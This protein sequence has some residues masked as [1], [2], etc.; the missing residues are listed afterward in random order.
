M[1]LQAEVKLSPNRLLLDGVD[2]FFAVLP[3]EDARAEMIRTG[4]RF[5]RSHRLSGSLVDIERLHLKLAPIG[6]P[7]RLREPPEGALLAAAEAVRARAFRITLD[8]AMRF[9]TPRRDGRFPFVLCSDKPTTDTAFNLRRALAD[10]QYGQGLLVPGV[11][12]YLPHVTLL[13]G[14]G[15][16]VVEQPIPPL[17]WLAREF[18]LIRRFFGQSR[19]EVMGRWPLDQSDLSE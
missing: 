16:E 8:C 6:R 11:S 3:D 5:V 19:H 7:D 17:S 2:M 13:Y 9:S 15:L 14:Q 4:E 12:S 1:A 18:V 10:A